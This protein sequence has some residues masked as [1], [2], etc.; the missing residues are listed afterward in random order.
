MLYI[1]CALLAMININFFL[2]QSCFWDQKNQSK[3]SCLKGTFKENGELWYHK[4]K[5]NQE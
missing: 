1:E 2:M 5:Q 3:W 4:M